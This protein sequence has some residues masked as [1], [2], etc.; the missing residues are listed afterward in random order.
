VSLIDA[1]AMAYVL[2]LL[3]GHVLIC[4]LVTIRILRV[5]RPRWLGPEMRNGLR[6]GLPTVPH[7]FSTMGAT[8]L[9]VLAAA[10]LD[11]EEAGGHMQLALLVGMVP[12]LVVGALNNSWAVQVYQATS[13]GE[14]RLIEETSKGVAVL[15]MC[16]SWGAALLSPFL[17]A[18]L[19]SPEMD[20]RMMF[21]TAAVV[22]G[23]APLMVIYLA[24]A[25]PLF[26][27]GRTGSLA[28]VTPI[29]LALSVSMALGLYWFDLG[30]GIVALAFCPL[31]FYGLEALF[32][33]R[34][35]RGTASPRLAL[36]RAVSV[37]LLGVAGCLVV[38][39][40]N[41]AAELRA[42]LGVLVL[43]SGGVFALRSLGR[44]RLGR[45]T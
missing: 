34:A 2:G 28:V 36:S 18:M 15:A 30:G 14:H 12:L 31:L 25:H 29:A 43:I 22:S 3:L 42:A 45:T 21:T 33:A 44:D 17:V 16:M 35:R 6:I 37:S 38:A 32:C 26:S 24:N 40:M 41:P 27:S 11:G 19:S 9:L 7:Q 13:E 39:V 1:S 4:S 5:H 23:A 8:S 10:R 20:R